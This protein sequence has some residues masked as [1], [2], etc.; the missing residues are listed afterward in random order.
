M[1]VSTLEGNLASRNY[2]R[3]DDPRILA[4]SYIM[5]KIGKL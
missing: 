2:T 4:K 5:Y 3:S 1:E